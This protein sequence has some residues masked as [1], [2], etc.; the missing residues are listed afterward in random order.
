MLSSLA[1]LSQLLNIAL[2]RQR[3]AGRRIHS[4]IDLIR[5]VLEAEVLTGGDTA[6]EQEF[7]VYVAAMGLDSFEEHIPA[8][9][10]NL[11]SSSATGP[12]ST[13][14]RCTAN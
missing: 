11:R 7:D 2:G 13:C 8:D 10:R 14:A 9:N 4:S 6:E 5:G 12:K 3:P 1:L